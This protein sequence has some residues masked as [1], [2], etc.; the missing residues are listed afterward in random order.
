M[1]D[2]ENPLDWLSFAYEDLRSASFL[3]DNLYPRPLE[4]ISY[5]CQQTVEKALKSYLYAYKKLVP[6]THDLTLLSQKCAD[7][8]PSFEDYFDICGDLTPVA[9]N[10]RYP[11][12][13]EI[14]EKETQAAL[15]GAKEIYDFVKNTM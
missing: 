14:T 7:I 8:N 12:K 6:K 5:H 9:V 4:I 1:S 13:I 2:S 3:Y 10:A 15:Q 11:N